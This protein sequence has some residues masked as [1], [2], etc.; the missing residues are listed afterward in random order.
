MLARLWSSKSS[1]SL[2]VGMQNGTTTLE[3]SLVVSCKT[4]HLPHNPAVELLGI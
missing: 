4:N 3:D 2:L 1:C